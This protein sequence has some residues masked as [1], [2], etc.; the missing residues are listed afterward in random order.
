M[1]F[2][3]GKCGKWQAISPFHRPRASPRDPDA[4]YGVPCSHCGF[5]GRAQVDPRVW[6]KLTRRGRRPI[7][8]AMWLATWVRR[9]RAAGRS[10]RSLGRRL[11]VRTRP[12]QHEEQP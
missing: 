12:G 3:C 4:V 2:R 6:A 9:L 11:V 1:Q 8:P 5:A 7:R 10:L